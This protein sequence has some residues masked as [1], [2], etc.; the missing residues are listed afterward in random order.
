MV[1]GPTG[2]DLRDDQI[3]GRDDGNAHAADVNQPCS[4]EKRR[5]ERVTRDDEVERHLRALVEQWDHPRAREERLQVVCPRGEAAREQ[6]GDQRTH[7]L[8][9][10]R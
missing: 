2:E 1:A 8:L 5:F 3:L 4:L 6:R 7:L 10:Q 9:R